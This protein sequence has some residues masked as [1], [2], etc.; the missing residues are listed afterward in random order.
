MKKSIPF[1]LLIA[2]L[3]L[4]FYA[5]KDNTSGE[6]ATEIRAPRQTDTLGRITNLE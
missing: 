3:V 6:M 2:V 1:K 5:C 4:I